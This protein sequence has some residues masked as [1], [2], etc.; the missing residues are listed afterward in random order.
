[1]K[2]VNQVQEKQ[3]A[4]QLIDIYKAK[5]RISPMVRR[6]PLMK[7]SPLSTLLNQDIYLKLE[8]LQEPG[9]FKV[10][11]ANNKIFS[12]SLSEKGRG[13]VPFLPGIMVYACVGLQSMQE[14][15]QSYAFQSALPN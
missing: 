1:M 12:L 2:V 4:L 5:E 3:F 13:V 15:Q 6:T 11:G 14:C 8:L 7:S 10:R 9:I